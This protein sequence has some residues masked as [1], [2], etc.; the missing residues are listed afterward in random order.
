[1]RAFPLTRK[2]L[3]R[4]GIYVALRRMMIDM[5]QDLKTQRGETRSGML[6]N[7]I[8]KAA[9]D[10][11]R[12][13]ADRAAAID[14]LQRQAADVSMS[15][16]AHKSMETRLEAIEA[17]TNKSFAKLEDKLDGLTAAVE[18]ISMALGSSKRRHR[19]ESQ[20]ASDRSASPGARAPGRRSSPGGRAHGES[21]HGEST[22]HLNESSHRRRRRTHSTAAAPVNEAAPADGAAAANVIANVIGNVIGN[23]TSGRRSY[24]L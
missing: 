17:R 23:E 5:L 19:S 12:K 14:A 16:S 13:L 21:T 8:S 3:R 24:E 10:E 2:S 20:S 4:K 18:Q 6:L 7:Q 9:H 11:E 1:M 15:G 22:A